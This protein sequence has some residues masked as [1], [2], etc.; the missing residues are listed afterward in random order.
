MEKNLRTTGEFEQHTHKCSTYR[1]A[2]HDHISSR[3][4]SWLKSWKAQDCTSLCPKTLVMCNSLPHLTLTSHLPHLS[5][6]QSHQ[7]TQDLQYTIHICLC[8]VPRQSGGSAQIPSLTTTATTV[9][10]SCVPVRTSSRIDASACAMQQQQ[11]QLQQQLTPHGTKQHGKSAAAP[12]DSG[13]AISTFW[14]RTARRTRVTPKPRWSLSAAVICKPYDSRPI[15]TLRCS[16]AEWLINTNPISHTLNHTRT[17]KHFCTQRKT[18][19]RHTQRT[20]AHSTRGHKSL[21]QPIH[22]DRSPPHC[23]ISVF[24]QRAITML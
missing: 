6:R 17:H 10:S 18:D 22:T 19:T 21:G 13:S 24:S 20:H 16:T 1:V 15:Y 7:H 5:F 23:P 11:Q 2:Q 4:H 8:E 12:G 3:E 14:S 9:P